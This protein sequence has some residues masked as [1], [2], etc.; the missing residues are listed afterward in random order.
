MTSEDAPT[1][2]DGVRR[3]WLIRLIVGLGFGIPIAIEGATLWGIVRSLLFGEDG[4]DDSDVHGPVSV[5]EELL[6]E[7]VPDE[8]LRRAIVYDGAG[9]REFEIAIEVDNV[10]AHPVRL[11]VD[12]VRTTAGTAVEDGV[13]T[14]WIQPGDSAT[15]TGTWP[16]PAGETPASIDLVA[17]TRRDTGTRA[18]ERRVLLGD[19]PAT[20]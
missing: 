2:D 19:V 12:G 9:D 7:T 11:R 20:S 3:R 15:L 14:D 4:D 10:S 8:T 18:V 17:V 6:P 16:L 13:S 1:E 5:G